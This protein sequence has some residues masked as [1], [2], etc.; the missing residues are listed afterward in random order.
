MYSLK[1][2]KYYRK[3]KKLQHRN[4]VAGAGTPPHTKVIMAGSLDKLRERIE[5]FKAHPIF[6][7][8]YPITRFFRDKEAPHSSTVAINSYEAYRKVYSHRISI[9]GHLVDVL[10]STINE[11]L[12]DE[13]IRWNQIYDIIRDIRSQQERLEKPRR[14]SVGASLSHEAFE[15]FGKD[16]I[17]D[18]ISQ[19]V[20]RELQPDFDELSVPR[21]DRPG[22]DSF[23]RLFMEKCNAYIRTQDTVDYTNRLTEADCTSFLETIQ[24][25]ESL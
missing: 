5:T 3:Y 22:Q 11:T 1:Y 14:D 12:S 9:I 4:W 18:G 8:L 24:K 6:S 20:R 15:W 17:L 13:N 25:W 21:E 16:L 23:Q 10:Q 19:E 2:K 7:T